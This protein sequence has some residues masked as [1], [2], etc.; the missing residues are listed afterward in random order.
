MLC[1]PAGKD[2]TRELKERVKA[3]RRKVEENRYKLV[4][5]MPIQEENEYRIEFVGTYS[6]VKNRFAGV[7]KNLREGKREY[8]DVAGLANRADF[9]NYA[10]SYWKQTY[11]LEG[12]NQLIEKVK[13]DYKA[14]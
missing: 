1:N 3:V 14:C 9:M 6:D 7:C 12:F 10:Q 4:V 11:N 8:G 13:D 5:Y 2:E